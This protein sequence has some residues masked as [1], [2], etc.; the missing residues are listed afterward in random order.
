MLPVLR[1]DLGLSGRLHKDVDSTEGDGMSR[2]STG[3]L[4]GC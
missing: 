3:V 1:Y 4:Q 2:C